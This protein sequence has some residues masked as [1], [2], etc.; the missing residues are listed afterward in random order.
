MKISIIGAGNVGATAGLVIAQKNLCEHLVLVDIVET[1]RGKALD[2]QQAASSLEFETQVEGGTKYE[3]I[4]ESDII[5]NTAG[6]PRIQGS[7][8]REE[9]LEKNFQIAKTISSS[10]KKF[11][12]NAIVMNV[13]NPVDSLT[14]AFYKLLNFDKSKVFGMGGLLDCSR[15]QTLISKETGKPVSDIKTMILGTHGDD[16]V[17]LESQTKI[18]GEPINS[19][20]KENKLES[21]IQKTKNGGAELVQILGQSGYIAPGACVAKQVEAVVKNTKHIF[22]L[23]AFLDGE[24]GHKGLYIGVPAVLGKNGVEKIVEVNLSENE[25]Q[26]F[27]KAVK[28]TQQM[29]RKVDSLL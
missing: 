28:T 20:V 24:Y 22:C 25:K 15:A 7:G 1:V 26:G 17:F 9:L 5:V 23:P 27:E 19:F 10:I 18:H 11:T 14:Y 13:A 2:I 16:M 6:F 21:I 3:M 12:P 8:S 4:A 29:C